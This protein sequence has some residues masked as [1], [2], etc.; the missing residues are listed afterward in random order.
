[1]VVLV[2]ACDGS[3]KQ[4]WLQVKGSGGYSALATSD[5]QGCLS[6]ASG[7]PF[8]TRCVHDET[9][10][11]QRITFQPN[12]WIEAPRFWTDNGRTKFPAVCLDSRRATVVPI[13]GATC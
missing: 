11:S 10:L 1:M 5:G 4:R 7:K 2:A 9:V 8:L 12:G 13:I 3:E 6:T